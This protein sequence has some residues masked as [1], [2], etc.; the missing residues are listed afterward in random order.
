M[1]A[2]LRRFIE[3]ER[4]PDR[5]FLLFAYFWDPHFD[6]IPPAPYDE[7]FAPEDAQR[8]DISGF[9]TNPSIHAGLPDG[10]K[11]WILAEY[12]GEL[13]WTDAH[14]GRLFALLRERG[15]WDDTLVIVT[16]DHGEEFFDHGDKGH[17]N[18]LYAETVHVPL[19]VKYPGQREGRRDDRL[20]SLVDVAPT[21]FDV[22]GIEVDPPLHGR[23][24]RA[25]DPDPDRAILYELRQVD[26]YRGPDGAPFAREGRWGAVRRGDDKL[27]WHEAAGTQ[28]RTIE[29]YDVRRDPVEARPLA[30][31]GDR[32]QALLD[33]W[34]QGMARV[35]KDGTR[36]EPGGAAQL[37]REEQDQLRALGYLDP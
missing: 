8:I 30:D 13:R 32:R 19:I 18:N 2:G 28:E 37:T 33:A 27:I 6:Y 7:M 29:V 22:T 1:E 20:V 4:D 21:V 34:E 25:P 14:L 16:A 9:D 17:K 23:S 5:P 15:L 24:L 3:Q 31:P 35:R 12:D 11:H 10:A 36:Y 26:Y